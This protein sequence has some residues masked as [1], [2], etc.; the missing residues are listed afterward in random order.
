MP[1]HSLSN[2][3]SDTVS[4]HNP[5]HIN[6][7]PKTHAQ[8]TSSVPTDGRENTPAKWGINGSAPP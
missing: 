4:V 6:V 5:D 8:Q 1:A 3:E 7:D 2:T